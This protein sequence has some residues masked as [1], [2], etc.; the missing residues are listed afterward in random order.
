M[1]LRDGTCRRRGG[2]G[3]G[4]GSEGGLHHTT[5][6]ADGFMDLCVP[7]AFNV[8]GGG[9]ILVVHTDSGNQQEF[10][11]I[12]GEDLRDGHVGVSD[13]LF[14]HFGEIRAEVV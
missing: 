11:P 14:V 9:G 7:D 1:F 12:L 10:D 3:L 8:R 4:S 13:G 2:S 6:L 5:E